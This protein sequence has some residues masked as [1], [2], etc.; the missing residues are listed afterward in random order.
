MAPEKLNRSVDELK[1][2]LCEH[3]AYETRMLRHC[4]KRAAECAD[5]LDRNVFIEAFCIHARNLIDF[6]RDGL[7]QSD[8]GACARHFTEAS[9]KPFQNGGLYGELCEQIANS[10]NRTSTEADKIGHEA[11]VV[12]AMLL[13]RE[14]R[15]FVRHL[16]ETHQGAIP[17]DVADGVWCSTIVSS[18]AL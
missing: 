17:R 9:Y 4:F 15:N 11:R 12:L 10:Y 13:E 5:Q 2:M 8:N 1:E 7:S 6:Y 18:D 16:K 14:R 3:W